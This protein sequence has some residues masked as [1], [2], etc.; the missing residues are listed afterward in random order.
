[1]KECRFCAMLQDFKTWLAS[2][3][4]A[5]MSALHWFYFVGLLVIVLSLWGLIFR[6]IRGIE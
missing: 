2:P 3:F 1:M 5:D 6:H 4:A